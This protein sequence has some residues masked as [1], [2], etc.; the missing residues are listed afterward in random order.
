MNILSL[1]DGISI[2]QLAL[3]ELNFKIDKYYASEIDKFAIGVTKYHFPNTIFIGDIREVDG[4]KFKNINLLIGGS[5]CQNFSFA[6][7]QQGMITKEKIEIVSLEQYLELKEKGFEFEGQS[8]LFWEYVRILK[9]VKPKYFLLENVKMAKKWKNIIS[10]ELEIEPILIDSKLVSA[11]R[12]PRLYWTNIPIK[13]LPEDKNIK[14]K[15]VLLNKKCD[16]ELLPFMYNKYGNKSRLEK[17]MFSFLNSDKSACLTT[18]THHH[19]KYLI[20]IKNKKFRMLDIIECERL[21]TLPDNYT[22]FGIIEDKTIIIPNRERHKLIGN[23]W[24]L[25]VIKHIFKFLPK[26]G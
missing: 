24:T 2:G 8:Y 17:N 1:F 6:G 15:E 26:E 13:D 16:R 22:K 3:K 5:S 9:E 19:N 10:K 12:R 4:N 20:D 14:L 18:G 7:K 25:E 21:Q 23:A 11:Q